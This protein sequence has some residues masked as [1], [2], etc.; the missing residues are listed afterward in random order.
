MVARQQLLSVIS[1]L[2]WLLF[3]KFCCLVTVAI[4]VGLICNRTD[5]C[6]TSDNLLVVM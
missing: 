6:T 1:L 2:Q 3:L 4:V 5:G